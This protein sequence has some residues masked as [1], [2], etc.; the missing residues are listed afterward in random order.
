MYCS[1]LWFYHSP[2]G[3]IGI[4]TRQTW[5]PSSS[6]QL[7]CQ[8]FCAQQ[9][10]RGWKWTMRRQRCPHLMGL[11]AAVATDTATARIG[12]VTDPRRVVNALKM[13]SQ[14]HGFS[15]CVRVQENSYKILTPWHK[16][17][18]RRSPIDECWRCKSTFG[19]RWTRT[20]VK[21]LIGLYWRSR[22]PNPIRH[23]LRRLG[24][25]VDLKNS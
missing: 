17:P 1:V 23:W 14:S 10:G 24:K 11:D 19:V 7:P 2:I 4:V 16:T 20:A 6:P 3:V 12:V 21:L 22:D 5:G 13:L 15:N 8:P 9:L 18:A 25:F